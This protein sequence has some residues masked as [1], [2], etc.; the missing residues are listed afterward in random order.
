MWFPLGVAMIERYAEIA[1]VQKTEQP[2][3]YMVGVSYLGIVWCVYGFI[4]KTLFGFGVC[5]AN[6]K[7][8]VPVNGVTVRAVSFVHLVIFP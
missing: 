5:V 1:L 2:Q 4:V 6:S 8:E 7:L 3:W